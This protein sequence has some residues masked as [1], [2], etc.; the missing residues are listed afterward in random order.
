MYKKMHNYIIYDD[1]R[2][3]SLYTN[4]FMT[5]GVVNGYHQITLCFGGKSKIYK[6]H[7]LVAYCFCNPPENYQELQVNHMDGN[8]AN[9]DYRN[10]EW[11]TAYENNLHARRMGLNNISK[12]NHERWKNES[13]SKKT[14]RNMSKANI[15]KHQRE[16]NHEWRYDIRDKSG[17]PYTRKELADTLKMSMSHTSKIIR[18]YTQ[19]N[20][21]PML[22]KNGFSVIDRAKKS[23]STIESNDE[24]KNLVC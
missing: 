9:N 6:V 17:R 24:K 5:H 10:L 19:G 1:G 11:C 13:F 2:I 22:V 8:K 4:R 18:D 14:R 7:R 12:A 23:Q 16:K 21:H 20:R 15:G 3:F